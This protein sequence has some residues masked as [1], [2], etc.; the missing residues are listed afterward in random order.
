MRVECDAAGLRETFG[1]SASDGH[2]IDVCEKIEDDPFAVG[3]NVDGHLSAFGGVEIDVARFAVGERS[4]PFR[5][6]LFF[7]LA[8]VSVFGT[9]GRRTDE[10]CGEKTKK[11]NRAKDWT[12]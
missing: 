6:G 12:K 11:K 7:F 9:R 8:L 4:I 3:R 2:A 1:F 5:G 10:Q